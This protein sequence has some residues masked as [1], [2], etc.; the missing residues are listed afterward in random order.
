MPGRAAAESQGHRL[1]ERAR[2]IARPLLSLA[3]LA[4]L[5]LVLREQ[6]STLRAD[7]FLRL[8]VQVGP[9]AL[10]ILVPASVLTLADTVGLGSC[11]VSRPLRPLFPRLLAIRISCDALCYSLPA[12]IPLGESL[13]AI[14]LQ[15][16]CGID[17]TTSAACCLLGKLNMALGH[18]AYIV[19]V[20]VG[21][22]LG[23]GG[24]VPLEKVPGGGAALL[25]GAGAAA[26]VAFL[27]VCAYTGPRLS[28]TI[29]GIGRVRT[30]AV[31][32]MVGKVASHLARIDEQVGA[33]ARAHP[34][35][36]GRSIAA[37]FGGWI[38]L[39]SETALILFLLGAHVPLLAAL[40]IE[41]VVSVL[42]IA[43]F[44]LPSAVGAAEVAYVG[45]L[46]ALGVSDP[47]TTS[48][49][50]ITLKRSREAL[51]IVAGYL[52]LLATEPPTLR[53][54]AE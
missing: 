2:R 31:Q 6:L 48:V 49:A 13:R 34:A 43:F 51:W 25:G 9:W 22:S 35:H 40:G 23:F 28:Q 8:L 27:L 15:R 1:R 47:V 16:R 52:V 36:L 26:L 41:A 24:K 7:A 19:L 12:G 33:L 39:A 54:K 46:T 44:F 38:A 32:R 42:R 50:F 45:I 18:M 30:S 21:L 11:I 53:A 3:V 10:L 14:L 17:F 20:L 4:I 29:R 5:V 37:F